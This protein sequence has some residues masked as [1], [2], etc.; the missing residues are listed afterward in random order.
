MQTMAAGVAIVVV[1]A[2]VTTGL[3]MIGSPSEERARRLDGR[4]LASLQVLRSAIDD[5]WRAH[6]R[7][8]ES[9]GELAREPRLVSETRDPV[10]GREYRYRAMAGASYQLCADFD[11]PSAS[12]LD[13]PFWAHAAGPRCFN[14]EAR[15]L[16]LP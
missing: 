13:V 3:V 9:I 11:R 16:T 14:L 15:T 8:P 4:R 2:A 1:V 5:Y 10:T 6:G 12:E 7:L